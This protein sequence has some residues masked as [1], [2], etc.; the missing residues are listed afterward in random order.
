[1]EVFK[2]RAL[3]YDAWYVKHPSLYK[4]ELLAAARLD[5]R[6]GV[7]V[8][9]G[10]GRFAAPLGLRAGVDPAREMLKL[11]PHELD[12]V[13]GVGEML[14]LRSRAF[15]CALLV[16]TLCFV[17]DPAAVLREAMRVAERVAACIVPG[18][19]AWGRR[20]REAAA[21]GHPFLRE[22]QVLHRKRS[23]GDGGCRPQTGSG[24]PLLRPR[25]GGDRGGAS[26]GVGGRG[27]RD[28]VCLSRVP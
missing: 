26:R 2:A 21:R 23:G 24:Y 19:S 20:Y 11:A 13:E 4:S 9:V 17:Q 15:T 14:P 28:G 8:G 7:E 3:D 12:L 25:R 18:D 10:T 1:V 22:G 6:G 5:C 16:V 27:R